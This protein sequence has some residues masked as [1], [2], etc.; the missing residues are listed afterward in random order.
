MFVLGAQLDGACTIAGQEPSDLA[1][2]FQIA[3]EA[4]TTAIVQPGGSR[5]DDDVIAA[6]AQVGAAMV[7]TGR[8]HFRH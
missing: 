5:R 3:L 8:R 2:S 7:F 4:G 1:D 6:V